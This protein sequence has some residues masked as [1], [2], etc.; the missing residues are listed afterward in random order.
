VTMRSIPHVGHV[1]GRVSARVG[2]AFALAL[3]LVLVAGEALADVPHVHVKGTARI[4]AH[5]ARASG[6]LVL[7]GTVVDDAARPLSGARV[8]VTVSRGSDAAALPLSSLGPA[9]CDERLPGPVIEKSDTMVLVTGDDARFCVRLSLGHTDKYVAHLESR[10]TPLVDGVHVDLPVDLAVAPVTLRFDPERTSLSLDAESTTLDVVA[11]TDDEGVTT[12]AA[13]LPLS[14]SNEAGTPLG[15][16]TTDHSGRAHVVIPSAKLGPAGR[17]EIRVAFAGNAEAGASRHA[18]QVERRTHVEL[19]APDA[20]EG[21]LPT[22]SPEDGITLRIVATARCARFGCAGAPTGSVEARAGEAVVGASPLEGLDGPEAHVVVTFA[23]PS[24]ADVPMELRYVPDAPWFERGASLELVQPVRGPSP[25]RKAPLVLAGLAVVALLIVVRVPRRT[26]KK[27]RTGKTG[28]AVRPEAHVELVR[29]APASH[30]W[31]GRVVDAHEATP[32]AAAIVTIERRG[33]E[34]MEVV[35][36]AQADADGAFALPPAATV[37]GDELVAFGRLHARVRKPVPPS[38]EL[39]I[40]LVA[41]KR[42]VLERLVDW[43]RRRGAPYDAPPEATPGH[44]RRAA[45]SEFAVA[46]WA[47][48]VER[49]AYG[50]QPVDEGVEEDVE[51]LQPDQAAA[52]AVA[53]EGARDEIPG[54]AGKTLKMPDAPPVPPRN[55]EPR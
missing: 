40:G 46:R 34:R 47:D 25:L 38:G 52:P 22:G 10:A 50:G 8:G 15:S 19:S 17:G 27:T 26:K 1:S 20:V 55:R 51:R 9:S 21:R 44:V 3:V 7:S 31:T 14:L 43:A 30:G 28:A 13:A 12:P 5:A 6:K 41:R 33:F 54:A 37:P 49:A 29:A 39:S 32:V 24:S 53:G 36:R 35:A 16:A 4:D 45:S 23:L 18:M 42:A 11:S 48:A 2:S